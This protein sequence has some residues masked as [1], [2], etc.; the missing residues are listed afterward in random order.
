M[1]LVR[2]FWLFV[3]CSGRLIAKDKSCLLFCYIQS[4]G[5][6][7]LKVVKV[8]IPKSILLNVLDE[9]VCSFKFGIRI[10]QFNGISDI[11]F[12]ANKGV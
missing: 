12:I 5:S 4:E 1:W 6:V 3:N 10:R 7:F 9:F 11:V 8:S 2:L